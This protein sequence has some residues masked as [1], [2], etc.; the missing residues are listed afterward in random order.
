MIERPLVRRSVMN[1]EHEVLAVRNLYAE[2][3]MT[4]FDLVNLVEQIIG[5]NKDGF[6]RVS[7]VMVK[8]QRGYLRIE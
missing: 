7:Q 4:L 3:K 5:N 8:T 6:G 2:G 1:L